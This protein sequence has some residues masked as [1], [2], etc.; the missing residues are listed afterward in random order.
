[1]EDVLGAGEA[2]GDREA[3]PVADAADE[4]PT[5]TPRRLLLCVGEA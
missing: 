5:P 1:M 4:A 2:A 3:G